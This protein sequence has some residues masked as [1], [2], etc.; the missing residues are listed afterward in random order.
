MNPFDSVGTARISSSIYDRTCRVAM[1]YQDAADEV[2]ITRRRATEVRHQG[3]AA[4]DER[5]L[6]Q[7]V[8]LVRRTREHRDVRVGSSVRGA[9]DLVLVATQLGQIRARHPHWTPT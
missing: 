4:P 6:G 9:I 1:D 3:R 8:D 5:W 2:E 7:V